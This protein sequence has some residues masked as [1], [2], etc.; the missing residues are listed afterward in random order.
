MKSIRDA[1]DLSGKRVFVRVDWNVP[2]E[3]GVVIDDFRIQASMPTLRHLQVVGAKVIIASHL[4]PED[5]SVDPLLKFVPDGMTLL[6]NLRNNPGEKSNNE[7]FSKSLADQADIYVNEAFSASHRKHASIVG[8]PK[9]LPSFAGLQ[10]EKEV[11]ELRKA[12]S[13]EHPFLFI[14]GGAKFDT[15]LPLLQKFKDTADTIFVGGALAHNFFK[16]QGENIGDSL[17]SSGNFDLNTLLETGKIVLPI[18]MVIKGRDGINTDS[19]A[20]VGEGDVI[21]D[22]GP[23]TL[24][25]IEAKIKEAKFIVWNGPLGNYEQGF[26]EYTNKLAALLADSDAQTI[27]GGADTLAAIKELNLFEKFS[28]V[29]TGGGAM[30]DFLANETLPGLEALD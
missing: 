20:D 28:L 15:K 13:P 14:L 26:K 5:S 23:K 29:S 10:F 12:F 27:V 4:E 16:E 21:V 19:L 25:L 2:I 24:D 1:G 11:T 6:P 7:E 17:V 18:D 30:L 3:N 8:V 9:L 22:A